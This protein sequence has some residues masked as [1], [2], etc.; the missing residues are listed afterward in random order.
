MV[1]YQKNKLVLL[2]AKEM[3][4]SAPPVVKERVAVM[5]SKM[6]EIM[7]P[8]LLDEQAAFEARGETAVLTTGCRR[9]FGIGREDEDG[10]VV[11][12][13]LCQRLPPHEATFRG[14]K[15]GGAEC[16]GRGQHRPPSDAAVREDNDG[17]AECFG[18]G[19]HRPPS[20]AAVR[21]DKDGGAA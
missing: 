16:E 3:L 18:R 17:G 12:A 19:Q 21:E 6:E 2:Q 15:G 7:L 11:V 20:D 8:F 5:I 1:G 13:A 4:R 14:D 9:G 10:G